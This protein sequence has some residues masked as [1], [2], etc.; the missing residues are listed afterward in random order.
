MEEKMIIRQ[1]ILKFNTD[2][3]K[4]VKNLISCGGYGNCTEKV[5]R[6]DFPVAEA[7]GIN[8]TKAML[9]DLKKGMTTAEICF[10]MT[11]LGYRPAN[12]IEL[13]SLACAYPDMQRELAIVALD[14]L[15][16]EDSRLQVPIIFQIGGCR[17]LHLADAESIWK[18][19][20]TFFLGVKNRKKW[21][22]R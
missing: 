11:K 8:K 3:T 17:C 15:C 5:A 9:F 4:S 7:K 21:F 12:V 2:Y 16:I 18:A 13:L 14:S 19:G 10:E 6:A 20:E 22:A 1:E